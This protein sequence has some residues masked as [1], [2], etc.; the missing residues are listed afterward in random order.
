M[1]IDIYALKEC[2]EKHISVTYGAVTGVYVKVVLK[3]QELGA[4]LLQLE[5]CCGVQVH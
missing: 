1:K 3:K 5:V 2:R 4:Q